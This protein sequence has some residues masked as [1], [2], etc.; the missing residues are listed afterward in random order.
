[1]DVSYFDYQGIIASLVQCFFAHRV[2]TFIRHNWAFTIIC[3]LGVL[4]F[5]ECP[6]TC[7]RMTN[8]TA[9]DHIV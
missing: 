4:Q 1:M 6:F 8:L 7:Q 5:C 3:I 2:R 9:P